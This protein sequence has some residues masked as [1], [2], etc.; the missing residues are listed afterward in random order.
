[1]GDTMASTLAVPLVA[2]HAISAGMSLAEVQW[3]ASA[4]AIAYAAVLAAAGRLADA[5]GR[6]RVLLVGLLVFALGGGAAAVAPSLVVL[7]AGRALQGAGAGAI[8]PASLALLLAHL[9]AAR[10]TLAIGA[11][12]ASS[13][14]GGVL[15]H[16]AGGWLAD[17]WGW[18]LLFVPATVG[19][20]ALMLLALTL[21]PDRAGDL[22][23]GRRVPDPIGSLMLLGGLA[24]LVLALT[25]GQQWDGV[26]L[27]GLISV[28][29]G[30]LLIAIVR[31]ASH[32]SPAVDLTLW[33]RPRF[34]LAGLISL[35]YGVVSL[36]LLVAAPILLREWQ[37]PLPLIGLALT[38]LSAGVLVSSLLAGREVRRRGARPVVYLGV[39]VVVGAALCQLGFGLQPQFQL[40]LWAAASLAMG[41]GLG[42]ISTGASAAA[43][44]TAGSDHYASAVGASM[45]ARQLGGAIG[46]AMAVLLLQ[47]PP[48]RGPMPGYSAVFALIIVGTV[49]A[50]YLALG[51][52]TD[53]AR[54]R[55]TDQALDDTNSSLHAQ[56]SV[57]QQRR[58]APSPA[59]ATPAEP[60]APYGSILALAGQLIAAIDPLLTS[61]PPAPPAH[62]LPVPPRPHTVPPDPSRMRPTVTTDFRR[63]AQQLYGQL[64]IHEEEMHAPMRHS[65]SDDERQAIQDLLQ[66]Y[67]PLLLDYMRAELSTEQAELAVCGTLLSAHAHAARLSEESLLRAWLYA[68]ARVHRSQAAAANPASTGTWA[69]IRTIDQASPETQPDPTL[70]LLPEALAALGAPHREVL[71]L[72]LRHG[73]TDI[74]IGAIFDAGAV[75]I[76]TLGEAACAQLETWIA[77]VRAIQDGQGCESLA[78]IIGEGTPSRRTRTQ[79]S[80]HIADCRKCQSIPTTSAFELLASMPVPAAADEVAVRLTLL[81]EQAAPLPDTGNLWRV[82]GFPVQSHSLV[83]PTAA[84]HEPTRE[85]L[86]GAAP[87]AMPVEETEQ[88]FRAWE[89]THK[90][91][92]EEMWRRRPDESDPEARLSWRPVVRVT[93][94]TAAS[95]AVAS[96]AWIGLHTVGRPTTVVQAAAPSRSIP[97]TILIETAP[98]D[99]DTEL[100]LEEPPGRQA[101]PPPV[102]IPTVR[103]STVR[104]RPTGKPTPK[105]A[106][107]A[108]RKP[109]PKLTL[110][111]GEP[112][113]GPEQPP[114]RQNSQQSRSRASSSPPSTAAQPSKAALP[115][116][117]PPQ[118]SASGGG[119]L[120]S[121]RS[122][123]IS[124]TIS[125]GTGTW[126]ASGSGPISVSGNTFTVSTPVSKPG[127]GG[128]TTESGTITISWQAS[129]TGDG[130]STSGTTSESGTLSLPVSWTVEA[131]KGYQY[132]TPSGTKWSNC[133]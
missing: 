84:A 38:P 23:G 24:S 7:V 19:G 127:C 108:S 55:R 99:P 116:P 95:V 43:T 65:L 13:G 68:V 114:G 37:L 3:V 10:R 22:A 112:R 104:A 106:I 53:A 76:E 27:L 58:V 40:P 121:G 48:L 119:S 57:P 50:G 128:P 81:L 86:S 75:Q 8:V 78:A 63:A 56:L 94:L 96:L 110:R 71:D 41:L 109:S 123:N 4:S 67:A 69:R 45:T 1:M 80:K 61:P 125:P 115:A 39:L 105:Q 122:G 102:A 107:T 87:A 62:K 36:A 16:S 9:P 46:V 66:E 17:L 129:N 73:L 15:L 34:L 25:K 12:S 30:L 79:T 93:A 132:E 103:P 126:S 5:V 82:D 85:H 18:R 131:D 14:L 91:W 59:D 28:A 88:A 113:T 98:V 83:E 60:A 21:P 111:A 74:E 130:T 133:N 52:R 44:L 33:R 124:V 49:A 31:S 92:E 20:A 11:W 32:R 90:D 100:A 64:P 120:G 2:E 42:M 118:A 54:P 29:V 101:S 51:L 26:M 47:H 77:A 6:R 97:P 70:T 117:P 72:A 35:L 89:K